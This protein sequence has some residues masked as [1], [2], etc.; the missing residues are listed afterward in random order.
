MTDVTT[1]EEAVSS[2]AHLNWHARLNLRLQLGPRGTRLVHNEHEGPLYVQKPFYPEGDELAHLYVLH[3]PGGLVSGDRLQLDV[4]VGNGAQTLLTTP[5]AGR[6]YRARAD[7]ALQH[8]LN[9]FQVGAGSSLEWLPLE[10]IIYPNARTRLETRVDLHAGARF[11]GWE[12]TSLGLPAC[13]LD[14]QEAEVSQRLT[15][16]CEGEPVFVEQFHLNA[17]TRRLFNAMAGMQAKPINA[18]FVAGPFATDSPFGAKSEE[19]IQRAEWIA[20]QNHHH[21][22]ALLN[23]AGP[24][25]AGESLVG[26]SLVGLS[27]VGDFVVGRYL[28]HCSEQARQL[29]QRWWAQ[30]RPQLL[31]RLACPPRIWFT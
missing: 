27:Q 16:T 25:M 24:G 23:S 17:Q 31:A 13:K 20:Q 11:I 22:E 3:P 6:V 12:V 8:Q 5:G 15:V 30:L 29:F 26:E 2:P 1:G 4:E 7:R 19:S 21:S 10:T 18:V 9:H 28:G 14:A